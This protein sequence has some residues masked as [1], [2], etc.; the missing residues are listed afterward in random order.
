MISVVY[1]HRK[2]L[3]KK[4]VF[5]LEEGIFLVVSNISFQDAKLIFFF[6]LKVAD[7]EH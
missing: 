5:C 2:L 6:F 1:F 4:L 7:H 3:W